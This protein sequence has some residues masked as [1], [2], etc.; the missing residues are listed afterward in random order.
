MLIRRYRWPLKAVHNDGMTTPYGPP[1]AGDWQPVGGRLVVNSS[2]NWTWF[3]LRVTGPK[4][5]INGQ[6]FVADWGPWMFDLP[7][8]QYQLRVSTCYLGEFG[9][10]HISVF[11]YP[12]QQ[13]TVYYRPPAAVF[14]DGAIGFT[15]QPTRGIGVS[16]AVG[17]LIGFVLTV[18]LMATLR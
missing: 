16:L 14:M 18:I 5:E 7:A 6:P 11:V 8:G 2:Y 9:P 13:T 12:R 4:I 3:M 15:P 10:A 1:P 17:A